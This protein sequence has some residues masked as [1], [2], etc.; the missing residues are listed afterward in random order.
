MEFFEDLG[1]KVGETVKV[2][3]DRSHQVLEIGRINIEIGKEEASIK[4][5]YTQIGEAVY[6]AHTKG[7][8][9]A[10]VIDNLCQE[11]AER[12]NRVKEFKIRI[13]ELKSP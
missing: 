12:W 11:I 5:L 10:E 8:E 2:I 1:K 13:S 9:T 3:G 4:R 7:D 6:R